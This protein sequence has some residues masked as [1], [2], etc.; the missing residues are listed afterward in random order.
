MSNTFKAGDKVTVEAYGATLPGSVV[1]VDG[2]WVRFTIDSVPYWGNGASEYK[3][4]YRRTV[5][6]RQVT[7]TPDSKD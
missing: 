7:A 3:T 5:D 4:G 6:Y 1:S 2:E